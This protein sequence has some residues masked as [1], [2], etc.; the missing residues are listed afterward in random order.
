MLRKYF[1]E[2]WRD[3]YLS[4]LRFFFSFI[5]SRNMQCRFLEFVLLNPNVEFCQLTGPQHVWVIHFTWRRNRPV[6]IKRECRLDVNLFIFLGVPM[7]NIFP[8]ILTFIYLNLFLYFFSLSFS[9]PIIYIYIFIYNIYF[10]KKIENSVVFIYIVSV[11][12]L[13]KKSREILKTQKFSDK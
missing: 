4:C 2:T 10:I 5:L 13:I 7:K 6:Y 12:M 8:T 3:F 1:S 11:F 9:L